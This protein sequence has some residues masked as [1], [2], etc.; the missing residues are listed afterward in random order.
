MLKRVTELVDRDVSESGGRL[1]LALMA[2]PFLPFVLFVDGAPRDEYP[3]LS[4][5]F[6]IASLGWGVFVFWRVLLDVGVRSKHLRSAMG[7]M[8]FWTGAIGTIFVIVLGG[9]LYW[10]FK[11]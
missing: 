2:F 3:V 6:L 1:S 7:P 9:L 10:W 11:G 8:K 5:F 4:S